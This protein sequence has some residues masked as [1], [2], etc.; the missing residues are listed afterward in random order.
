MSIAVLSRNG[1]GFFGCHGL[2]S[3]RAGGSSTGT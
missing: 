3:L 1:H 2:L